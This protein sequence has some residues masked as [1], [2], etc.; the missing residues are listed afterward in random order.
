[1]RKVFRRGCS[2]LMVFKTF[3]IL[4]K[5]PYEKLFSAKGFQTHT[6]SHSAISDCCF[7]AAYTASQQH[8]PSTLAYFC[9]ITSLVARIYR[10]SGGEKGNSQQFCILAQFGDPCRPYNRPDQTRQTQTTTQTDDRRNQ[11]RPSETEDPKTDPAK[12]R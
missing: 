4:S 9:K 2:F 6:S 10:I 1:M 5:S 7:K 11:S 3:Q 8:R 12:L